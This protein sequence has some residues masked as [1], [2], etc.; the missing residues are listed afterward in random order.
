MIPVYFAAIKETIEQFAAARFVLDASITFD[1][2][3]GEQ[4]Y[5]TGLVIFED[6]S[7][8]HFKEFVD[9]AQG[10]V[11]KLSY[12]YHYQDESE[13]LLF[14]YDNARHKPTL[15]FREH[16]HIASGT[17]SE[18][19]SPSLGDVLMEVTQSKGWI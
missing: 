1:I 16:K 2:R 13:I 8:L 7:S 3:P 5:L 14:R 4:G 6:F 10:I 15:P 9:A 11:E 12:S 18:A 17:I 19:L